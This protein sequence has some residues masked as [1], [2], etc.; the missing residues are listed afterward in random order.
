METHK[1][2]KVS[3]PLIQRQEKE[4]NRT[5]IQKRK[6]K[7]HNMCKSKKEKYKR[8]KRRRKQYHA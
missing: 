6:G 2:R 1:K 3:D 7:E 4:Q 8:N 5:L